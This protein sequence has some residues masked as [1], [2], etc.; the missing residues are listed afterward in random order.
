[1]ETPGLVRVII[2]DHVHAQMDPEVDASLLVD[3][4]KTLHLSMLYVH[5]IKDIQV[6]VYYILGYQET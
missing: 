5:V 2:A 4:I 1:M 6:N 3:V